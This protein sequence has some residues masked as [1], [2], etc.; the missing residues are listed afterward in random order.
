[1]AEITAAMVKEL[2]T[3][4]DAPMMDCKKVLVEADGDM[5]K[6][7]ELLKER[8]I[9]KAAKKA[10]RVAAEGLAG[11]KIADDFSKATVVE[12][13]S[14]TDFV[15]KN[16]GFQ[17]LVAQTVEEIYN[18]QP[19]DVETLNNS[20]FGTKFKEAVAKIGEKIEV[21]RFA[22]LEADATTALN[23]YIHSNN[24]IAV[25]V[26]A[27][28]DS[29]KTA[30]AMRDVMKQVAMHASA[31]KPTTLS[32]K[33]FDADYVQSET[34][35]R[36]EVIKKENEELARLKK[37]LKNVPQ[38]ISMSQLTEEVLAKAE[39][40]IKAELTAQGKPEKIWDKIVPGSLARFIDDNTT[41]DKEQALLDQTYVLNDKFTVA[42]AVEEAAKAVGGTAVITNFVRLEVGEG[43]EKVVDDFAAEVAAQMS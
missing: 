20:A 7:T 34:I 42:Q 1:M 22:T 41:L 40:D 23:G 9:A 35:G 27:Q 10:D 2:R 18:T 36:I 3:A 4:T 43:I 39:A 30:E 5:A 26:S 37:P 11:I 16:E 17:N 31:M 21:R 8:G 14:E 29:A 12:I 28:C 19:A 25:I 32:Y 6:A 24:R 33:D 15:A 38:Y 13:N